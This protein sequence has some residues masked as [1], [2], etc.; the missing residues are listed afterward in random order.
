[1]VGRS[2]N[3]TDR[4]ATVA[5]PA[6]R[7][8]EPVRLAPTPRSRRP[9]VLGMRLL[10]LG[11]LVTVLVTLIA[12]AS[13]PSTSTRGTVGTTPAAATSL[14]H[15]MILL[16]VIADLVVLG[17][18]IYGLRPRRRRKRS[19]ELE[20]YVYEPPPVHWAWKLLATI[21]P[22]LILVGL[23][24]IVL[25][26]RPPGLTSHPQLVAPVTSGTP[27]S[28]QP[29]SGPGGSPDFTWVEIMAA[30]LLAAVPVAI[31]TWSARARHVVPSDKARL[32]QT[33]AAVVDDSLEGVRNEGEPRQAVI[34]AY[35]TME[36]MLAAQ[37]FPR[38]A[39]EAPL[40]Y[41][42]RVFQNLNTDADAL[43]TL[44]ELFELAKFSHH[45]ISR[46]MKEQAV[47][48]LTT[49]RDGLRAPA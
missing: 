4:A 17:L 48:A 23:V 7:A 31:F 9:P 27:H 26:V 12:V 36:R 25:A 8:G 11:L 16:A 2:E 20:Q 22:F 34:R 6:P 38:R 30:A 18:I 43:H 39:F 44:T 46:A 5:A 21:L 15:T 13:R 29:G 42:A 33:L 14:V 28:G 3:H 10:G 40:E 37:G 45:D 32:A 35:A 19:D 47:S 49:L 24:L 1:V 41:L